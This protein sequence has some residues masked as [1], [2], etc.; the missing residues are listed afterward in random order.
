MYRFFALPPESGRPSWQRGKAVTDIQGQRMDLPTSGLA[1]LGRLLFAAGFA[2]LGVLAI[3]YADFAL[4]WQPVPEATPFRSWLAYAN[5]VALIGSSVALFI[6]RVRRTGAM[7]LTGML[8]VWV[9]VLHASRVPGHWGDVVIW[10]GVA[11]AAAMLGGALLLWEAVRPVDLTPEIRAPS[12][13]AITARWTIGLAL[14]IFGL[15]H[16]VYADFTAAM[17]P[18]WIPSKLF[19][20]YFTGCAH[21]AAGMAVLTGFWVQLATRMLAIMFGSWVLILHLPRVFADPTS[22]VEWT[23]LFIAMALTASA[24]LLGSSAIART[25]HWQRNEDRGRR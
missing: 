7:L 21:V 1:R 22:R 20:A 18:G 13:L 19:W 8:A 16:F 10:L 15:S 6:P 5:G 3:I 24:C 14:P 4:Q 2:G 25:E 11:E 23:M 9:F 17:V 12:A